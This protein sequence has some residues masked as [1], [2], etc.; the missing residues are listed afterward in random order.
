[1]LSR[2]MGAGGDLSFFD[3]LFN[4]DVGIWLTLSVGC[5]FPF[6]RDIRPLVEGSLF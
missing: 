5:V 6:E 4:G 2:N 1:M 3:K